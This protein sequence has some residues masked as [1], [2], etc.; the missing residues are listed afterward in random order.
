MNTTFSTTIPRREDKKSPP[1]LTNINSGASAP[2]RTPL[3]ALLNSVRSRVGRASLCLCLA[4]LPMAYASCGHSEAEPVRY[5]EMTAYYAESLT[6]TE[7]SLDS[8]GRFSRKVTDF[9]ALHP[10]AAE[11]PLYPKIQQ[12]ISTASLRITVNEDWDGE[13]DVQF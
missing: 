4:L 6:L 7:V 8:V 12:N 2:L 3:H 1:P 11:D 9:V 5:E 10:A 13:V